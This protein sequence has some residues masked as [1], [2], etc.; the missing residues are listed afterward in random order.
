[1]STTVDDILNECIERLATGET[2]EQC[3]ASHPDFAVE[4]EPLLRTSSATMNVAN[5]ITHR[6]EAKQR[7][8]YRFT[9]A[10]ADREKASKL[11]WLG[12]LIGPTNWRV[13]LARTALVAVGIVV[14]GTGTAYGATVASEDSVPGDPLYAVK[15]L[16]EDI[17][18]RMPKSDL[19]RA[20]EHAH[21]AN[22]R[23]EEVSALID[24]GRLDHAND[25]V[26]TVTYH[27]NSCAELVGVTVT[28]HANPL[29]MPAQPAHTDREHRIAELVAFYEIEAQRARNRFERR[30][31][32]LP[33]HR[34]WEAYLMMQQWELM[35]RMFMQALLYEGTPQWTVVGVD[36]RSGPPK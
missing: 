4:L 3:L 5:A 30:M 1:M 7:S 26:V 32:R 21:L 19:A 6:E 17:S 12:R 11:G 35:H 15:T 31:R 36:P 18:L 2:V 14:L 10:I 24:R 9:A 8:R 13:K 29:E 20:K 34:Q 27:L 16:K 23:T 25:H 33:P 22:V 28:A